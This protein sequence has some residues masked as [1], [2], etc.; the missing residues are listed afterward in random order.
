MDVKHHV[1]LLKLTSLSSAG[2]VIFYDFVLNLDPSISAVRLLVGLHN[3][4]SKLGEPSVLPLVYTEPSTRQNYM[5]SVCNAVIGA[6]QPVP[7]YALCRG[8]GWGSRC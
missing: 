7:R 6:R 8:G 1:Y 5:Q 2:F 3:L 4:S